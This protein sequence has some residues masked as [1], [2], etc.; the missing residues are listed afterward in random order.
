MNASCEHII[1]CLRLIGDEPTAHSSSYYTNPIYSK[2]SYF[3]ERALEYNSSLYF[4][5]SGLNAWWH[6]DFK[7]RVMI[8]SYYIK[9]ACQDS[10]IYNWKTQVSDDKRTWKNVDDQ[11]EKCGGNFTLSRPFFGRYF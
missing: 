10:W 1:E 9:S 8:K 5:L 4:Y 6:V 11:N 2:D 3:P 7:T